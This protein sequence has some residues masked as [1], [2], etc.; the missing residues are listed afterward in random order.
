MTPF[1]V[2]LNQKSKREEAG[3]PGGDCQSGEGVLDPWDNS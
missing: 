2:E 1:P 3:L